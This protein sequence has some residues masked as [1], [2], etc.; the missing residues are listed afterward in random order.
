[1][2]KDC[3]TFRIPNQQPK[4]VNDFDVS[5]KET[6]KIDGITTGNLVYKSTGEGFSLYEELNNIA[7]ELEKCRLRNS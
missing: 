1:M 3:T 5:G 7:E 6:L 2:P 4:E